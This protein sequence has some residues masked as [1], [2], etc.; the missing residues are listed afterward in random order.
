MADEDKGNQSDDKS[1]GTDKGQDSGSSDSK[2]DSGNEGFQQFQSKYDSTMSENEKLTREN[3]ELKANQD[4]DIEG[5]NKEANAKLAHAQAIETR[6]TLI[7]REFPEIITKGLLSFVPLGSEDSM[8][9]QAKT[10]LASFDQG[11][12]D[13]DDDTD[14]DDEDDKDKGSKKSKSERKDTGDP[15]SSKKSLEGFKKLSKED[16]KKFLQSRGILTKE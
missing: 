3:E 15:S 13:N 5:K 11:G 10:L 12:D 9:E 14:S 4:P 16:K 8:R 7:Q 6:M 2:S 1:Q